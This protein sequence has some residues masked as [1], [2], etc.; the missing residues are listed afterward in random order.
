[1]S[2][3]NTL[4]GLDGEL[5]KQFEMAK[6][7]VFLQGFPLRLDRF[8]EERNRVQTRESSCTCQRLSIN[9]GR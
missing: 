9:V 8:G 5:H 4:F 2:L 1:M 6:K 7:W 3:P